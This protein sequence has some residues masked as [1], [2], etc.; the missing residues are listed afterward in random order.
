MSNT[1]EKIE[2]LMM[3]PRTTVNFGFERMTK[4]SDVVTFSQDLY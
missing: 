1:R 2:S 4:S 3:N